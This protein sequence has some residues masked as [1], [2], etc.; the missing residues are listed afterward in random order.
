MIKK[1]LILLFLFTTLTTNLH[2]DVFNFD[3]EKIFRMIE[4][5]I[6]KF[7]YSAD[8]TIQENYCDTTS[9]MF[10]ISDSILSIVI[11][12]LIVFAVILILYAL[13]I[14]FITDDKSNRNKNLITGAIYFVCSALFLHN[15]YQIHEWLK[16]MGIKANNACMSGESISVF[17]MLIP[18]VSSVL[19]LIATIVGVILVIFSIAKSTFYKK[20]SDDALDKNFYMLIFGLILISLSDFISW[21]IGG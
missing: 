8:K 10:N 4:K 7:N 6:D 3:G 1:I 16:R 15:A 9:G 18:D 5:G 19:F 14:V 21:A 11:P 2:A 12:G 13:Y 17:G 20:N